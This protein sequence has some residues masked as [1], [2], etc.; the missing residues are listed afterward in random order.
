M[1]QKLN[2]LRG[3]SSNTSS[4]DVIELLA[5]SASALSTEK[6]ITLQSIS[7]RNNQMD[8]DLTGTN[9]QAVESLNKKLNAQHEIKAEII[10]SSSEKNQVKG[11][12]RIQKAKS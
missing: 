1:E 8:I 2:E 4:G 7:F 9:L 12:I 6:N 5:S 11:S 3:T 10:T